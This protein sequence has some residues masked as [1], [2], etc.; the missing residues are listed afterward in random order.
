LT[1]NLLMFNI[2]NEKLIILGDE[3]KPLYPEGY[4]VPADVIFRV[5]SKEKVFE[6]LDTGSESNNFVEIRGG[7]ITVTN[8][9]YT[10]EFGSLCPPWCSS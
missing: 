3:R 5:Y 8:G 6:L 9:D 7:I 10:L 4:V 1:T 2:I